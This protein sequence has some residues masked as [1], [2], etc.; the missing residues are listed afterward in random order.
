[1]TPTDPEPKPAPGEPEEFPGLAGSR[2]GDGR[3]ADIRPL[4]SR[5]AGP[6]RPGGVLSP[7]QRRRK[8]RLERW[9]IAAVGAVLLALTLFQRE[10]IDLGPGLSE[11][12]GVV[13]LVSINVSV[14]LTT[15]LI[16]LVLRHLYRIFF[17][18]QGYGSL[19]TKMVVAF[20]ALSLLPTLLIFYY[21]YRQLVRGHDLWFSPQIEEALQDSIELTDAALA[22]DERLLKSYGGDIFDDY[23]LL[24]ASSDD[25]RVEDFLER[26]RRRFHLTTVELYGPRG[27]LRLRAG[28]PALPAIYRD[29]FDKQYATAP[30]WSGTVETPGGELTRLVWPLLPTTIEDRAEPRGYLVIGHLTMTP[31]RSQMEDVRHALVGYRDALIVQRPFRVTQLTALTAMAML[32]VFISVWIGSHLARSLTRPVLDLV[33]GT[34]K[35]AA[36]D[37]DFT[38]VSPGRTGEFA[39]LVSAFNF[40]TRDLKK[41]YLE[42]DSRRRFL[43]TVLKNVSTGVVILG[44]DGR[45]RHFNQAA[46]AI[47]H[48][49]GAA[50][51]EAAPA[52]G[53]RAPGFEG[54]HGPT[55]P[56]PLAALVETA[57][58]SPR[59]PRRIVESDV[60]LVTGEAALSLRAGVIPL[61]NDEGADLGFLLTFDNLTELEKAQ[62]LAAWR[63]V[64][65]RIAHDV[66]NPLTPIQLSAQRLRRRFGERLAG[67]EDAAVFEECTEVIIRQVEEM[68]KLVDEFSRFAR[69]PEIQ[70]RPGD[71]AAFVE[72]S[73][74]LFRQAHKKVDFQ[75]AIERRPPVFSFDPDQMRRVL[76]NILDNAVSAMNQ[77]G[78][79]TL[80]LD[81]DEL[82]GVRLTIADTGPGLAPEIRDNL[83]DPH[84][85]TKE[86]GQGLGLAIVRTIINDHG[87]FIKA[88]NQAPAGA[89]FIIELPLRQ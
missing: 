58:A 63:E 21:S 30:P 16:L 5:P 45:P 18:K 40:M 38:L 19:Q 27:E 53:G 44:T 71:F 33:E 46:R 15:L 83:F 4:D 88:Q 62:R 89:R 7:E 82:A 86:S 80:T 76:T 49:T 87:G 51:A 74:A 68:K 64:A 69:L 56:P 77:E 13:A 72:E 55:L 59:A 75:L 66:K 9:A 28:D 79:V 67:Q 17:E 70:P 31:I 60:R 3:F 24:P 48:E 29:W 23:N 32:A 10:V 2:P 37:W 34:Q 22:M 26:S 35:V 52:V 73:L 41:M 36:G 1:M 11:G 61:R 84:V 54:G 85:T 14:L 8:L 57:L 42:L 20:I 78:A 43:E 25:R 47:L 6:E 39:E 12:R 65:R 81:L 50:S